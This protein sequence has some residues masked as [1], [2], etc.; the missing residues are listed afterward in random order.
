MKY[1]NILKVSLAVLLGASVLSGCAQKEW[2]EITELNLARC[3]TPGNLAARVDASLGDVVTFDWSLIKDAGGYE[4]VVYTDEAMTQMEN[5]WALEPGEVPFTTRLTADQKY[6]FTVQAYRVDADGN[7]VSGTESH[8]SV[9]DGSIKTYAVKDN[10]YLEVTGRSTS[11]VS[12]AWS[13]EVE[14]YTEVTE[15]NAVP[16]KGGATVKKELSGAEAAAAA[17]TIDGLDPSTEYQITL[18]YMS[19]SRG[20]VDT[21]TKAEQGSA[22]TI[23][24]SEELKAAVAAGGNYYLPYNEAGY[25]MSTAKP[26]G[27]LTL[28]GELSADGE[29]TPVSGSIDISSVLENGSSIRLENLKFA[30]NA[31]ISHLIVFSED[32]KAVSVD[33]IEVVNCEISGYKAGLFSL[34]KNGALTLNEITFDSCDIFNI[35]GDGGDGFDVRKA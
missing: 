6:W 34:N 31:S 10:L 32:A 16:V 11:S 24:T 19:A 35:V 25:S 21:W 27:D 22:V 5:S 12:L 30:D 7:K 4:L 23:T 29:R 33:K 28:V 17:A 3:L 26:V 20:T 14:D 13:N 1:K 9:Y 2:N 15:L 8:V 18:F